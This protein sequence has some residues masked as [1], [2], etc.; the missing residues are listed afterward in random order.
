MFLPQLFQNSQQASPT[1]AYVTHSGGGC[2]SATGGGEFH[3]VPL[4]APYGVCGVPCEGA[5]ALV[6]PLDGAYACAGVLCEPPTSLQAGEVRLCSAGGAYILLKNS[7]DVVINGLTITSA[8]KIV[9][10]GAQ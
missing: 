7:G 2:M 6:L 8:G 9:E 4:F 1:A 10:S 5:S 3:D